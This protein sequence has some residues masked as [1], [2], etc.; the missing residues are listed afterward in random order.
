MLALSALNKASHALILIGTALFLALALNSPVHWLG[1]HLPGKRRGNRSLATTISFLIIIL[2]L[3]GFLASVMPPLIRQ[4]N[5]FVAAVPGLVR[6]VK[7][8]NSDIGR[9]VRHYKLEGQVQNLS[10]ELSLRLKNAGGTAV[11]SAKRIGSS[12]FAVVTIL[13]LTFMM[14]VE[15]PR[16]LK[17]F[18]QLIPGEHSADAERI[19]HGMYQVI[20]GY[21]NGQVTLALIAALLITPMLFILGI[22]YPVALIVVIFLCGLIPLVGHTIGAVIISLV[23]LFTSPWSALIIFC[24]YIFYQQVENYLIQPHIQASTT[25]L[26]PLL[27]FVS[28]VIG[29]S[30]GGLFGGLVAIPI[31]GCVRVALLDYLH[32]KKVIMPPA[33]TS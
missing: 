25:H 29:I 21:A 22:S 10:N 20:K 13:V 2:L 15:G 18:G 6:E 32:S 5:D 4:T 28:L 3:G 11:S 17:T 14:L 23:A 1:Q 31:A 19:G 16:W 7:N 33:A 8:Q 12:V 26:S 9:F 30:F 27:V 24:Y